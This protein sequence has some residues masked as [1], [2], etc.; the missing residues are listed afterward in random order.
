M[1]SADVRT[2]ITEIVRG[3][4][5]VDVEAV[6]DSQNIQMVIFQ[7]EY[8]VEEITA[9]VLNLLEQQR[10]AEI[11]TTPKAGQK[12]TCPHCGWET[13]FNGSEWLHVAG[14]CAGKRG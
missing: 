12:S 9:Y 14:P 2:K 1:K 13:K 7:E 6:N 4:Y 3:Y 5:V 11:A 10:A 8:A